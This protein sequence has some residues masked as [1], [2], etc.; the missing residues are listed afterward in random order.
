M[1]GEIGKTMSD[2]TAAKASPKANARFQKVEEELR[3][4][5]TLGSLMAEQWRGMTSMAG[6]F[7]L[8]IALGIYIRPYYD[9]GE[10]HAFGASGATQVRY[11]AVELLAIFAFTA[12]IIFLARWGKAYLIKYGMYVVLT[13]ALL[14]STVPLA[15][16]LVLDFETEPFETTST[17]TIEGDWLG[18]LEGDRIVTADV[19]GEFGDFNVNISLWSPDDLYA[20]PVWTTEHNHSFQRQDS[21]VRL[22]VNG[23][24]LT[25]A[26]GAYAWTLS[27]EDGSLR[28]SHECFVYG[29][30]ESERLALPNLNTGCSLALFTESAQ[31]GQDSL[32]LANHADELVRYAVF[33]SAPD[34]MT[35]V[36]EWLLPQFSL[37]SSFLEAH[38]RHNGNAWPTASSDH[39][40]PFELFMATEDMVAVVALESSNDPIAPGEPSSE[41]PAIVLYERAPA[42]DSQY[43]SVDVGLSPFEDDNAS[44]VPEDRRLILMGESNGDVTGVTWNGSAE[45]DGMFV[46][47]ERMMLSGLVDSVDAVTITD[48]DESGYADLLVTGDGEAHWFYTASLVNR[49]TFE[50]A[51]DLN[52]ALFVVDGDDATLVT[53]ALNTTT[54]TLTVGQGPLTEGMFPLYGLQLLLWPTVAGLVVTG[55]LMVLLFVHSEWYVVNTTGVLLGAG[56]VV[57]LGVTFVP[58]LA[59]LFMILAAVYDAWAVYRSKHMLDLADTMIG[60]RLPI[61]LV[62]PQDSSYSLIEET[63]GEAPRTPMAETAAVAAPK[64]SKKPK[65][66]AMFMGLG[67]VIFPGM[68]VLSALQWLDPSGAFAVAMSTLVGG[69]LGYLALMTY[70]ARGQA[71]AGLPLLNGGAILGYVIGGFLFLNGDVFQFNISW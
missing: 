40:T 17:D 55:L 49:A 21:R 26:S 65:G 23:D 4:A 37:G 24:F 25:F 19:T 33:D 68:L 56:V 12:L 51:D 8:T 67:D 28:T 11:V 14:Y 64:R 27:A 38:V 44:S 20:E 30:N 48:L 22:S 41:D 59:I 52:H 39:S 31:D 46:E 61:L 29:D 66:E 60:L 36:A 1:E 34:V 15:H 3:Q 10:L 63:E 43:T 32:Y 54:M 70:V 35:P 71:Q 62:A 13:L 6:M 9:V 18:V 69:L 53:M 50:V 58:L 42:T 2:A 47:E 5:D 16:M 57:M 7:V 45:G